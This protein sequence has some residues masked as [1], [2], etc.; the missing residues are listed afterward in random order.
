MFLLFA[1]QCNITTGVMSSYSLTGPHSRGRSIQGVH[2][3]RTRFLG[4]VLELCRLHNFL[5]LP[6]LVALS[7]QPFLFLVFLLLSSPFFP[8]SPSLLLPTHAHG[9]RLLSKLLSSLCQS[10]KEPA[11]TKPSPVPPNPSAGEVAALVV[12]GVI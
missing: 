2:T 12:D 7:F 9:P 10:R 5:P 3:R 6:S 4:I 1:T 8:L 11:G